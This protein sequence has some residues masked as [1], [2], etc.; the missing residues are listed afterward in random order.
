MSAVRFIGVRKAFGV[1]PVL[2]GLEFAVEPGEVYGLLG[3]NGCGKSTAIN[4][5][6]GLLAADAG[7]V[8]IGPTVETARGQEGPARML[9]VCPQ[10]IALYRD[11]T[12]RENLDFFARIYGLPGAARARRV[13]QVLSEM[14][15]QGHEETPVGALSGGLQRRVNMGAALVNDPAILVLDEPT[16]GVDV[17]AR[18]ELWRVLESLRG[19]GMTILLTTHHLDE[20]ER[21]CTHVGIMQS[22][23]I[24]TSGTVAELVALV[25]AK[26]VALVETPQEQALADR[27]AA[28]GWGLRRYGGRIGCLLPQALGLHETV[29]LL[30]GIDVRSVTLQGVTLEHAYLE[31]VHASDAPAA[32]QDGRTRAPALSPPL[33]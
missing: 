19:R 2:E 20:A 22:G 28:L 14:G 23:R 1:R 33:R 18:H 4:I 8:R 6:C 7:E 12:A 29:E 5:L 27:A 21:L 3:P 10:E 17:E 15:L 16:A 11:L 32:V 13:A 31:V 9:G 26:V 30:R 24:A 25:P